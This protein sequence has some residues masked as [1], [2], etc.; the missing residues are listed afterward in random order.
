M[1]RDLYEKGLEIRKAVLS[2][3]YVDNVIRNADALS[4][5]MQELV[6]T[7]CWGAV[8][9]REQLDRRSRSLVNLG[10]IAAL[11]RMHELKLHVGGALRNGV[12]RE[13][14]QEVVLQIAVYCGFPAAI[15]TL[16]AVREAFAE[17]DAAA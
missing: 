3:R 7:F 10:I 8:W 13:E 15:D 16:R 1:Q 14:V 11:G 5:P 2:D 12:T 9:G 6:T 17:Y 4:Q